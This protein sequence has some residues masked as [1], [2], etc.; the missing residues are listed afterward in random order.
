VKTLSKV[1]KSLS[2]VASALLLGL[3]VVSYFSFPGNAATSNL[4]PI[5]VHVVNPI[6][7]EQILPTT[8]SLPGKPSTSIN[9]VACRDEYEPASFVMRSMVRDL[10]NL[11][12]SVSDLVGSSGTIPSS[13]LNVRFV[14]VWFQAGGGWNTVG[15]SHMGQTKVLVPEL[16]LKDD[17]LVQLNEESKTN[18]LRL[19]FPSGTKLV[20]VSEPAALSGRIVASVTEFPINDTAEIQP[21]TIRRGDA[22]QLWLTVH[23]PID[24]KDG[25]YSGDLVLTDDKGLR[26][27]LEINLQVL[28]V[29]LHAPK[30]QYSIYYRG[31]LSEV[32]TISSER[33]GPAQFL[34]ELRNMLAHGV[35]NP[36]VYQ[37]LDRAELRSALEMRKQVG[38]D[39]STLF[40]L[41]TG[42]GNPETSGELDGLKRR[43][44]VIKEIAGAHGIE[45]IYLYGMDEAK[46]EKLVSQRRAWQLVR[47]EG[48][49]V[50]TAG[51]A[52]AF[53][54]VGD[55]L[56][57]LVMAGKLQRAQAENFH[58]VGHKIFSY[59]NPPT[60]PENPEIF[61]RNYGL[62]LWR[63]NYDGAMPY[64][65]Q[66]SMAFTW[67]DF[68]HAR[69]RDHNFTYPT[70]DGVIDT[71][72]W[73]GFREGV[74]D[75]R[76]VTTL[77]DMLET[78]P[79][80][81][82]TAAVEANRYLESLRAALPPNL[83]EVRSKLVYHILQ[84]SSL[85]QAAISAV[86]RHLH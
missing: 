1:L 23:V 86:P 31:T 55:L 21:V 9:M 22:K 34:A 11:R 29:D 62:E 46:G 79:K 70:V 82:T 40:Y 67:N 10:E 75:V 81:Y 71:L 69:Y 61:R 73:E 48:V 51:Q 25:S 18:F 27:T 26:E 28:P 76:Y 14:K 20:S 83:Q 24:A 65:Y 4:G 17:G 80:P 68:D 2:P 60:G 6:S 58:Q 30:I 37:R 64:A 84:L 39:A 56:D 41:G 16:L 36:T 49:K 77:E 52:E 33:K 50:F 59:A 3:S 12:I 7:G 44:N 74:D 35:K 53:P 85:S 38:L 63:N 8:V 57:L 45:K 19:K 47:N 15:L 43:L 78:I 32:P 66:D 54:V 5:L 13:R 42:T 72:A